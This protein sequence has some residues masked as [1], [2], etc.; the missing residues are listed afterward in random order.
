[1]DEVVGVAYRSLDA[2]AQVFTFDSTF[3]NF[4][5]RLT[6][7]ACCSQ[8]LL[9]G[10]DGSGSRLA[11]MGDAVEHLLHQGGRPLRRIRR[12]A[13]E[14]PN[15]AGDNGEAVTV[16]SSA[17]CLHGGVEREQLRLS[18]NFLN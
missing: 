3:F 13:G 10:R 1:G 2:A 7:S 5:Q 17:R 15:L 9:N 14:T 12:A 18:G 4:G 16:L 8:N 11:R 6:C